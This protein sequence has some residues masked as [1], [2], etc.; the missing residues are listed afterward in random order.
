MKLSAVF[1]IYLIGLTLDF[2]FSLL[3][4]ATLKFTICYNDLLELFYFTLSQYKLSCLDSKV[5]EELE[6]EGK[7]QSAEEEKDD[8]ES[9]AEI[10]NPE[11]YKEIFQPQNA[12][13]L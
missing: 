12:I 4:G 8:K 5:K 13:G 6:N 1:C 10:R 3:L 7:N 2:F 11:E 9:T